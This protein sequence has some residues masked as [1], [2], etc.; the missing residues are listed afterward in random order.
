MLWKLLSATFFPTKLEHL[1][2]PD[3]GMCFS[4]PHIFSLYKSIVIK[5]IVSNQ[6]FLILMLIFKQE[7]QK[8]F[9]C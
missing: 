7:F 5:H 2:S 8:D 1:C 4:T 6:A 3:N 9:L